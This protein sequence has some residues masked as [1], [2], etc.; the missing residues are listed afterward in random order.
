MLSQAT[1]NHDLNLFSETNQKKQTHIWF[2]FYI[3]LR[4]CNLIL[5][6]IGLGLEKPWTTLLGSDQLYDILDLDLKNTQSY[7]TRLDCVLYQGYVPRI[8]LPRGEFHPWVQFVPVSGQTYLSVHMF[9][10]GEIL[11]L[12]LF[13]PC[14]EDRSETQPGGNSA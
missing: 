1:S 13:R 12:P 4:Y 5:K 9:I 7:C 2:S 3:Q 10:R 11:T 14:L 6:I 8:I